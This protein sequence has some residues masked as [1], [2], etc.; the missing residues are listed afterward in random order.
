M[1]INSDINVL[2]SLSDYNFVNL[3]LSGTT[4]N[5]KAEDI[6]QAYTNIKT[7]KSYKRFEKAINSTLNRFCN[8]EIESLIKKALASEGISFTSMIM[9]FW[10]GSYNNELL[11]YLNNNIYFP[12]LFSGRVSIRADEALACLKELRESEEELKKWSDST[13]NVTASKYLTFMKKFE[14]LD[15]T[16]KKTIVHHNFNDKEFVLFIYWILQ[17][18]EKA[19]ILESDWLKYCLMEREAFI[20]RAMQKKYMKF[21]SLNY[22]GEKMKIEANFSCEEICNELNKY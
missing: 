16:V 7:I 21:F 2:G 19:N 1:N 9:L 4:E 5:E 17:I 10:N 15:G 3:I 6:K 14:L 18:E 22:N 20:I 13:I 8:N 11:A 12:A